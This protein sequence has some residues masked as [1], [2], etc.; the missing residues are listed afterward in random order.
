MK[1]W[2]DMTPDE[3]KEYAEANLRSFPA[4]LVEDGIDVLVAAGEVELAAVLCRENNRI[5]QAIKIL[6][7]HGDYLWAAQMARNSGQAGLAED[8]LN[9]GLN[10]YLAGQMYG[11]AAS[12][13]TA[14]HLPPDRIEAIIREGIAFESQGLDLG[15]AQAAL[16]S[17]ASSIAA[18]DRDDKT[19]QDF[20][21]VVHSRVPD[22]N[23]SYHQIGGDEGQNRLGPGGEDEDSIA[24]KRKP[25]QDTDFE[26]IGGDRFC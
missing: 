24:V 15:R 1:I 3:Q 26:E 23:A 8:L 21:D 10:F 11:R 14:L 25:A 22:Q 19:T 7:E 4:E 5:P 2:K 17:L 20:L 6:V 18:L 9:E 16:D 13:A 12:A